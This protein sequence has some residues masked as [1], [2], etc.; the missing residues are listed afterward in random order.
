ME[1]TDGP[2]LHLTCYPLGD[3]RSG[4]ILPVQTVTVPYNCNPLRH[5]GLQGVP[6]NEKRENSVDLRPAF[7]DTFGE[8]GGF[9][10]GIT[11]EKSVDLRSLCFRSFRWKCGRYQSTDFA[12]FLPVKSVELRPYHFDSFIPHISTML[13]VFLYLI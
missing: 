12:E 9:A 11:L 3:L 10:S 8:I 7:F 13:Q 1:E 4:K 6:R 2:G 5:K